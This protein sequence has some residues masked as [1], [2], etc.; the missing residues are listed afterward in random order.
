MVSTTFNGTQKENQKMNKM[1]IVMWGNRIEVLQYMI[2]SDFP[3]ENDTD[4]VPMAVIIPFIELFATVF[5]MF[6]TVWGT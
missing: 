5:C 3:N 1:I 2:F 4:G 6:Q